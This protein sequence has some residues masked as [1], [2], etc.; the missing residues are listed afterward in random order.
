M[1]TILKFGLV[2]ILGF[3]VGGGTVGYFVKSLYQD[4]LARY[5]VLELGETAAY[6]LALHDRD[7]K[8]LEHY[9]DSMEKRIPDLV[10]SIHKDEKLKKEAMELG[11]L[12]TAKHFYICTKT[13]FPTEIA[14]I[15]N[16]LPP[17]AESDCSPNLEPEKHSS[18]EAERDGD[19]NREQTR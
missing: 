8:Y 7:E 6:A 12:T 13:P 18:G 9:I 4:I 10:L 17:V 15:M 2:F 5:Y 3:T 1:K 14:Q 19:N 11:V 16:E